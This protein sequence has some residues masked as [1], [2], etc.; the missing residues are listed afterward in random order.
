[1]KIIFFGTSKF[2]IPTLRALINTGT[3]LQVVVT[4][5][6]KPVGRGQ[7][8]DMS[9]VKKFLQG[10]EGRRELLQPEKLD[11]A[12]ITKISKL[13]P[14]IG[15]IASYGKILPQ[16]LLDIFPNGLL[17]IHPS[18]LPEYRGPSPIQ[19]SILNGDEKTG[20]TIQLLDDKMDHGP[21]L[22]QRELKVSISN[23]QFLQL[24]DELAKLGAEL[25]METLPKWINREVTQ[26]VQDESR[27]TYTKFLK[28]ED[29]LIDWSKP[30]DYIERMVRAYNP[31]PGTY[32][33]FSI[34]NLPA[35]QAGSQFSKKNQILKIK[36]VEVKNG[37]LKILIVQPEG[38][39]EMTY[40][41]FLRGHKNFE[42][43]NVI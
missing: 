2:A 19:A 32:I 3:A 43:P 6:D 30:A 14:N 25:L 31:W 39:K 4:Q 23:F 11:S 10:Q 21:I 1:M 35:G 24:Y 12:F 18:L 40:E 29:G 13:H 16:T 38:K 33:K 17:N 41:E 22:A 20:V 36:K 7:K 5:P 27:A 8:I 34:S 26:K 28:K 9:P 15:V 42:L 37:E